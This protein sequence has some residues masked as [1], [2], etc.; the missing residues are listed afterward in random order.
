MTDLKEQA[1]K[2][3]ESEYWGEIPPE[4]AKDSFNGYTS[5]QCG[6]CGAWLSVVRPGKH[7]CDIC[8]NY[9]PSEAKSDYWRISSFKEV[10]EKVVFDEPVT[11]EQAIQLYK[12]GDYCDILDTE[13]YDN[14]SDTNVIFAEALV[15]SE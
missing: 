14:L 2:N 9:V 8:G 10:S 6:D 11:Q 7:Q 3:F 5:A 1:L 12:D 13:Y 4:W 15:G